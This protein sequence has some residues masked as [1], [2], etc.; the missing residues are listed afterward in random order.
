MCKYREYFNWYF[1]LILINIFG[2]S[3][4]ILMEIDFLFKKSKRICEHD[5]Y[6]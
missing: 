4:Y 1:K 6:M 2:V 3:F 5:I